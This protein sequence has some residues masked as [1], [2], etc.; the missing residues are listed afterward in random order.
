VLDS[1][2]HAILAVAPEAVLAAE[3]ED[4]SAGAITRNARRAARGLA[5]G[6]AR[7]AVTR[8]AHAERDVALTPNLAVSPPSAPLAHARRSL[9]PNPARSLAPNRARRSRS[10]RSLSPATSPSRARR[11]ARRSRR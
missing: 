11:S 9:T 8:L 7:V 1:R 5:R 2:I 10:A 6:L 3:A 4:A